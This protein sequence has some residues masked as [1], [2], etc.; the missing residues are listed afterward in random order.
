MNEDIEKFLDDTITHKIYVL[1]SAKILYK[2]L[3]NNGDFDLAIELL[4]RC[5]KHDDSKFEYEEIFSFISIP[6]NN[7]GM[8]NPNT[9]M[10]EFMKKAIRVHWKNNR[11]HPEY[12]NDLNNMTELDILEMACDCY[13]RSI[14]FG[15]DL[16][17][18]IEIRQNER[19]NLPID[20]YEKYKFYCTILVSANQKEKGN[21]KKL[22]K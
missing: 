2:Y 22:T 7:D 11:H 19:F 12:H 1:E 16:L 21:S 13:S 18:F 14:Q 6:K 8:K 10:D 3:L 17:K 9:E 15:T 4:K 5:A 20:I